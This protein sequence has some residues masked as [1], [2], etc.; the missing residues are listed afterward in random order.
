MKLSDSSIFEGIVTNLKE[1]HHF[2]EDFC[3]ILS[4]K[5]TNSDVVDLLSL[6]FTFG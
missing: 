1:F 6:K 5:E 2:T 4:R 3:C